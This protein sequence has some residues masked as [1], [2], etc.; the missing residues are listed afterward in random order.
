MERNNGVRYNRRSGRNTQ[1]SHGTRSSSTTSGC[2]TISSRA[3]VRLGPSR[4][5]MSPV[6]SF[7]S[8]GPFLSSGLVSVSRALYFKSWDT[9]PLA[10]GYSPGSVRHM[11]VVLTKF[12]DTKLPNLRQSCSASTAA[13]ILYNNVSAGWFALIPT[14]PSGVLRLPLHPDWT[15]PVRRRV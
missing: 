6:S 2:V 3:R 1:R 9:V 13:R 5:T 10:G 15:Y 11:D 12:D 7:F 4:S 8:P 14:V